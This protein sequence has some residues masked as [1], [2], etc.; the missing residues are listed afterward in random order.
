MSTQNDAKPREGQEDSQRIRPACRTTLNDGDT[1][2]ED[3]PADVYPTGY[4][5]L[6]TRREC[7]GDEVPEGAWFPDGTANFDHTEVADTLVRSSKSISGQVYHR[8]AEQQPATDGGQ[9][10]DDGE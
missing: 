1:E 10:V 5:R 2:W 6:C 8:P 7:F 9:E 4:P 3:R